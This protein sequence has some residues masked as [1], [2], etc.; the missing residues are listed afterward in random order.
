MGKFADA[1]VALCNEVRSLYERIPDLPPLNTWIVM[2]H[3]MGGLLGAIAFQ[4]T[5]LRAFV[6]FDTPWAGLSQR[7]LGLCL[8]VANAIHGQAGST[9]LLVV[10]QAMLH[11]PVRFCEQFLEPVILHKTDPAVAA[12]SQLRNAGTKVLLFRCER[13]GMFRVR[14]CPLFSHSAAYNITNSLR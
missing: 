11:M 12:L 8:P 6:A 1:V 9:L 13:Q 10:A 7:V 2:A 5:P 3:S 4:T 14:E